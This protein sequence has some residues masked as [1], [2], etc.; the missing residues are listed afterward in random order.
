MQSSDYTSSDNSDNDEASPNTSN[1]TGLSI[2]KTGEPNYRSSLVSPG[3]CINSRGLT[4]HEA[5]R[6]IQ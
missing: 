6:D 5:V 3:V 2:L 4:Y 1:A